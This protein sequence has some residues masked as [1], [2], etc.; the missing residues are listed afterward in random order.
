MKACIEAA[1]RVSGTIEY[2]ISKIN[3]MIFLRDRLEFLRSQP[4]DSGP[5][6]DISFR[7]GRIFELTWLINL[8]STSD[9]NTGHEIDGA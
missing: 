4:L 9:S 5:Q 8:I 6:L 7:D 3:L 2:P 1:K